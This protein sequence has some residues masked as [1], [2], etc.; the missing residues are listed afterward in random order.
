MNKDQGYIFRLGVFVTIAAILLTTGVYLIGGNQNLFGSTF[1]I[2]SVFSNV[3]GLQAGNNVRF[4]GVNVGTVEQIIIINDSTLR[5]EMKIEETVKEHIKKDAIAS[6]GSDG[7]VGNMVVNI[8]W[9][10]GNMPTIEDG[11]ILPSYSRLKTADLLNT[12]GKTNEN[13]AIF[14]NDL[15]TIAERINNGK[16]TISMFL[17]DSLMAVELRQSITNIKTTTAFLNETSNQ[18]KNIADQI[19]SGD[20]LV[21]T[22]I[23]D[24]LIMNRIDGIISRL[25]ESRFYDQL[26]STMHYLQLSS[27]KIA[28]SSDELNQLMIGLN[29]GEGTVGILLKDSLMAE[30]LKQT[31]KNLNKG[32]VLLNEDL[33]A[34]QYNFLTK[35]YFK[36]LEKEAN[37]KAK[38]K[39]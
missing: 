32:S 29:S 33:K 13:I 28:S 20:G 35:K 5:V 26:D 6:I 11:D 10:K 15:L 36:K 25:E 39:N 14:S 19:Q 8:N 38:T 16:G 9:G 23:N 18:L 21:G 30:E 4:G 37:K 24:T 12:L 1:R 7:L 17:N 2:S 22:L 3:N 27:E 34:L 31:L